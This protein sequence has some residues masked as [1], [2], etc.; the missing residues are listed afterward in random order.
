MLTTTV[1]NVMMPAAALENIASTAE[2]D[3]N[4]ETIVWMLNYA[5]AAG[6]DSIRWTRPLSDKIRKELEDDG[7]IIR[8]VMRCAK[9]GTMFDICCR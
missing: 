1:N 5:G 6:A 3:H 9:P 7:Y 8:P 4:N 2:I